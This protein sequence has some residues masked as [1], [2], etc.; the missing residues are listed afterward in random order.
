MSASTVILDTANV[1]APGM[2]RDGHDDSI[3][4]KYPAAKV[5]HVR[6]RL[7]SEYIQGGPYTPPNAYYYGH[8]VLEI[9]GGSFRRVMSCRGPGSHG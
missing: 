6:A 1:S 5:G 3:H 8:R 4:F 2:V 7:H 9:S